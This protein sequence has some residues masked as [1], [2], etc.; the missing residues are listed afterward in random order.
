MELNIK[1]EDGLGIAKGQIYNA[2]VETDNLSFIRDVAKNLRKEEKRYF[3]DKLFRSATPQVKSDFYLYACDNIENFDYYIYVEKLSTPKMPID[4]PR[5]PDYKTLSLELENPTFNAL[6][7]A[8][9]NTQDARLIFELAKGFNVEQKE[10]NSK[11]EKLYSGEVYKK[12]L[13][14]IV[15]NPDNYY[16]PDYEI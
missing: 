9:Y 2:V 4:Y 15:Y 10:V 16:Q 11:L 3:F 14:R 8:I 5:N 13:D 6:K 7:Q 12:A 1:Y